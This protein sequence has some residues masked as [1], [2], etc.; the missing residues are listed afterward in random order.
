VI[1]PDSNP[2]LD[3]PKLIGDVDGKFLPKL[4]ES[5]WL[6]PNLD[7]PELIGDVD[8]KFLPKLQESHWLGPNRVRARLGGARAEQ[9]RDIDCQ[10]RYKDVTG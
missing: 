4:Q 7:E 3:E 6:G 9:K 8:G 2:N 5:H 10:S 1:T